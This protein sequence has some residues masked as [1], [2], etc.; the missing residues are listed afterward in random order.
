ML[1]KFCCNLRAEMLQAVFS[2]RAKHCEVPESSGY[3]MHELIA[4]TVVLAFKLHGI[5]K[6]KHYRHYRILLLII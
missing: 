1:T 5:L 2:R 6:S 3:H 4:A